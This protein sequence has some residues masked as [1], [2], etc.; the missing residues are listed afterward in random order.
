MRFEEVRA[1]SF[2]PFKGSVLNL[3]PGF[4]L[5]YGP[6]ESGKSTWHAA[7]YA[8]LCGRRRARGRSTGPDKE[9]ADRHKPWDADEWE[10]AVTVLLEDDRRIELH[11]DLAGMVNCSAMDVALG[12]KCSDEIIKDG[13][14]DGAV[15][16]GL[17][18]RSFVATACIRQ[19][20]L[21][22]VT[23]TPEILQEHLQRAVATGG[24]DATAARALE[25]IDRFYS[26]CVGRD[27]A[28]TKKPLRASKDW[29]ARAEDDL[30]QARSAHEGYE[31]QLAQA[32]EASLSA[33]KARRKVLLMEAH[34]A[35]GVSDRWS[36]RVTR[37]RELASLHAIAPPNPVEDENLVQGVAEALGL[38]DAR[39]EPISLSGP[40]A[41]ELQRDLAELPELPEGDIEP[42]QDVIRA[43]DQFKLALAR[44]E[45]HEGDR[46]EAEG[47]GPEGLI[48][49]D[50]LRRLA[51]DLAVEIVVPSF[52]N[53]VR[54]RS[55]RPSLT[56]LASGLALGVVL[57]VAGQTVAAVIAVIAGFALAAALWPREATLGMSRPDGKLAEAAERKRKA[58]LRVEELGLDPSPP[59]LR[60]LADEGV[61][62]KQVRERLARWEQHKTELERECEE[63]RR[64]LEAVLRQRGADVGE[65]LLEAVATYEHACAERAGI[66]SEARRRPD[67]EQRLASRRAAEEAA[68]N[69]EESRQQAERKIK[70]VAVRCGI[71]GEDTDGLVQGLH[72]WQSE[73]AASIDARRR[74]FEEWTT[75]QGLLDGMTLDELTEEALQRARRAQEILDEPT[76]SEVDVRALE[77]NGELEVELVQARRDANELEGKARQLRGAVEELAKQLTSVSDA[78]VDLSAAAHELR[79]VQRLAR[80]LGGTKR[81]M[82]DAQEKVHR[83]IAPRLR[84]SV[85]RWLS[86]VTAGR[87]EEAIVDPENLGV[88]VR[89]EGSSWRNAMLL[90]HGTAEQVYLLLRVGLAEHLTKQGEICP[91]ILDDVLVQCDTDRKRAV[92]EALLTISGDRQVILFTQ[93]EE[94]RAWGEEKLQKSR[95]QVLELD[96]SVIEP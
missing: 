49:P 9:F 36:E 25:I 54:E 56:A 11:H 28:N 2:G 65:D 8:G 18:R 29:N 33:S 79:R 74:A 95:D 39:P 76:I 5:V 61:A 88:Q 73:R 90:S 92:L 14:P 50:E 69:S 82:Q 26:E 27:Q 63:S 59:D 85:E 40:S 51:D 52:L 30:A 81:F 77:I 6:N 17:D 21:L 35:L 41:E 15:W 16:L 31:E 80:T 94:V 70:E 46:P 45:A 22:E 32:D 84:A 78:E 64:E 12:R 43:R 10:I 47:A 13:A 34:E 58:E 91:L 57:I 23:A 1:I 19:T 75:L 42:N 89:G 44:S 96:P 53:D 38:W 86:G 48:A 87:Y 3:T 71:E 4:N 68:L 72:H 93:E 62:A 7:L 60:L 55:R 66:A 37:A 24:T 20:E 67:R 83:D